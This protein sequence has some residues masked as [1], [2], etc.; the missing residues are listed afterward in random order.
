MA[1]TPLLR[2]PDAPTQAAM[3][4]RYFDGEG[5]TSESVLQA[6]DLTYQRADVFLRD[7]LEVF[8]ESGEFKSA[9][10]AGCGYCCHT[11]VSVLP[12]EALH[13]A[14]Y[15]ETGISTEQRD[16]F[17][18][19]VRERHEEYQG[20]DGFTRYKNRA[21]CPFLDPESWNCRLHAA[22]PTVCRAMHS[23]SLASCKKAYAERDPSI[24]APTMKSFFSYAG[25]STPLARR[26]LQVDPV[27]LNA[28]LVTIWDSEGDAMERWL[29][30]EP[31][32]DDALVSKFVA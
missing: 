7:A 18:K 28:A 21:A 25:L 31:I 3:Y 5:V 11:L 16:I 14:H 24:P 23:G 17:K 6:V 2:I 32:F 12:P 22:R 13:V 26:G 9:C 8:A 15:L 20:E 10:K 30:G 1:S 4:Q 29:A 27:E 19:A